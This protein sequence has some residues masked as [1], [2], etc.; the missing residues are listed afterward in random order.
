MSAPTIK[1]QLK[2]GDYI[3]VNAQKNLA[4]QIDEDGKGWL[5]TSLLKLLDSEYTS[6]T[7]TIEKYDKTNK[8]QQVCCLFFAFRGLYHSSCIFNSGH[9]H[10]REMA[11]AAMATTR[12][13]PSG[14]MTTICL[15]QAVVLVVK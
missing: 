15:R 6:R 8:A 9:Q 7:V 3:I 5:R 4:I 10:I 14:T 1:D 13:N 12:C 11:K 2:D